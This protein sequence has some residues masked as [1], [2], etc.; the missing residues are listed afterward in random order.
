MDAFITTTGEQVDMCPVAMGPAPYVHGKAQTY[1]DAVTIAKRQGWD[2][3]TAHNYGMRMA[4]Y[5]K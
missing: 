1:L 2:D 5:T 3:V 4:G